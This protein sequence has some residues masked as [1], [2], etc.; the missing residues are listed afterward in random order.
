[1]NLWDGGSDSNRRAQP[2]REN[3]SGE[4][5]IDV[6]YIAGASFCGSTLLSFVLN[7]HPQILSI[8]EMGPTEKSES[9]DYLCSCGTRLVECP[10]FVKVRDRMARRGV[11]LDLLHWDLRHRYSDSRFWN[12]VACVAPCSPAFLAVRDAVRD[13]VPRWRERIDDFRRRNKAFMSAALEAAGKSVF[14]DATKYPTRIPLLERMNVSLKVIHLVR[15]PRG[16]CYSVRKHRPQ[17]TEAP[18]RDWVRVNRLAEYHLRRLPP[19]RWRRVS[20]E[21]ICADPQGSLQKLTDFMGVEPL[22]VPDDFRKCPNHVIGNAMRLPSD[23][24]VTI[25]LDEK[26][27]RT[28]PQEDL[29]ATARIAGALGRQYG[30]EI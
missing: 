26:W 21:S 16:Y 23:G 19:N 10:F 12:R 13:R 3:R 1:M 18:A 17:S 22:V 14:L 25:Q 5:P 15:D 2:T 7:T 8:G 20:Y 24:R 6:V 9:E 27:R 29:Q 28:L 11:P 4:K 30:F